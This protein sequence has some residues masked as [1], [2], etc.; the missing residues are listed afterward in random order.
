MEPEN[1]KQH[2]TGSH[3]QLLTA[4]RSEKILGTGHTKQEVI[5]SRK[6]NYKQK[7]FIWSILS[8]HR[9]RLRQEPI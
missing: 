2:V 4:V 8:K 7:K 9:N 3:R 6:Q 1:L 5:N